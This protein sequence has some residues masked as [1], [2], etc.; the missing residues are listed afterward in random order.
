MDQTHVLFIPLQQFL[1]FW[2]GHSFPQFQGME[3]TNGN[4]LQHVLQ[5]MPGSQ[6]KAPQS[7]GQPAPS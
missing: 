4:F 6:I 1:W 5:T 3:R 2:G 7:E